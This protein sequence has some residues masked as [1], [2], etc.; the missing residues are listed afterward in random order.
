MSA[1]DA[2]LEITLRV[3]LSGNAEQLREVTAEG[4]RALAGEIE[5]LLLHRAA[6][7]PG[8]VLDLNDGGSDSDS[9]IPADPR[10]VFSS[11]G[12]TGKPIW[13]DFGQYLLERQDPRV[14][15]LYRRPPAL[16]TQVVSGRELSAL[17][18]PAFAE[19]PT[20]YR[21]HG[22]VV[23]GWFLVPQ[24]KD[25]K[26]LLALT[27]QVVSCAGRRGR[28]R[29]GLNIL[30]ASPGGQPWEDLWDGE[31]RPPW[32]AAAQWGQ[33]VLTSVE[34]SQGRKSV[35]P[36]LLS[37][38]IEGLLGGIGRRL[39]Q[40]HRARKRRTD[41]A[42]HRHREGDRP[43]RMALQDLARAGVG[44]VFHDTRQE[45]LIVLGERG[46]AHVFTANGPR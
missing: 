45:T 21:I 36:A 37:Q 28:R 22:Q 6:F 20:S 26:R 9:S 31:R 32:S 24:A 18:L 16:V 39:E 43:T 35:S 23:A 1:R 38:R 4:Q 29:L 2:E 3:P 25:G 46:R 5:A 14:D 17:L 27:L 19:H 30:G 40:V 41:H 33:S 8:R 42:Q 7:R 12:P 34:R 11:Y 15:L 44:D 10:Q 13:V